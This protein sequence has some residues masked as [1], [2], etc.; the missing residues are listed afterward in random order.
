MSVETDLYPTV[1]PTYSMANGLTR[2][3]YCPEGKTVVLSRSES[4][5]HG[6]K[7]W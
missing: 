4:L 6:L 7:F 1:I 2:G 5:R 3:F